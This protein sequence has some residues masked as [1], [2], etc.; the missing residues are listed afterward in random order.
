MRPYR[1][2]RASQSDTWI[3][4]KDIAMSILQERAKAIRELDKLNK[5]DTRNIKERAIEIGR[6]LVECRAELKAAGTS[7][8]EWLEQEFQW[9]QAQAYRYIWCFERKSELTNLI[10]SDLVP[11]A[12]FMLAQPQTAKETIDEITARVKKGE[13]VKHKDVAAVT[14][15]SKRPKQPKSNGLR[16][17]IEAAVKAAGVR[18]MITDELKVQFPDHHQQTVNS[19]TNALVKAG[20]FCD[21]KERRQGRA[22]GGRASVVYVWVAEADRV[23]LKKK[24]KAKAT[25]ASAPSADVIQF[26]D[27]KADADI[28][29]M[30]EDGSLADALKRWAKGRGSADCIYYCYQLVKAI[31]PGE[32][33]LSQLNINRM[34]LRFEA[35]NPE[36]SLTLDSGTSPLKPVPL[37]PLQKELLQINKSYRRKAQSK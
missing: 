2:D 8:V 33:S 5:H 15:K 19:T 32:D 23:S 11:S 25:K 1:R 24:A 4:A 35:G 17:E 10:N 7:W 22:E 14:R 6:Y 3:K 34:A 12:F 29:R 37:T 27:R 28:A 36:L 16:A 21:S 31:L 30:I 18:G 26:A 20:I 13:K 9:G